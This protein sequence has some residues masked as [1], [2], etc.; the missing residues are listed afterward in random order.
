M[1]TQFEGDAPS[2]RVAGHKSLNNVHQ[3]VPPIKLHAL[4]RLRGLGG[5][6]SRLV[7]TTCTERHRQVV[8]VAPSRAGCFYKILRAIFLLFLQKGFQNPF[9]KAFRIPNRIP[10]LLGSKCPFIFVRCGLGAFG[11]STSTLGEGH[12]LAER[13]V[14]T[15]YTE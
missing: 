1:T 11:T 4:W 10:D 13:A 3:K 7:T 5:S 2:N 8:N 14:A 6:R 12:A 15:L 9:G